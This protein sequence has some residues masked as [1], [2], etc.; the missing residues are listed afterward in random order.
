MVRITRRRV[1]RRTTRRKTSRRKTRNYTGRRRTGG[2]RR[3]NQ[4]SVYTFTRQTDVTLYNFDP[5][6][7]L[8]Q[9]T[10][11]DGA[12]LV[13]GPIDPTGHTELRHANFGFTLNDQFSRLQNNSEFT[14]LFQYVRIASI[15]RTIYPVYGAGAT[16][17]SDTAAPKGFG[18][19][20]LMVLSDRDSNEPVTM[21]VARETAGVRRI[22]MTKPFRET[23]SPVPAM[24]VG[25]TTTG[26]SAFAVIPKRAPWLNAQE[27]ANI[28]HYGRRYGVYDWPG[29]G[30]G[31]GVEGDAVPCAWRIMSTY[32]IQCKGLQ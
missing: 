29:P 5:E 24:P 14:Q 12:Y 9:I 22:K 2:K 25:A 15:T 6:V 18:V 26:G 4:N 17:S 8:P 3:I 23:F 27:A 30:D 20:T 28:V 13:P 1:R 19:P 7:G 31:T 16:N 10:S 32:R 11:S 21:A